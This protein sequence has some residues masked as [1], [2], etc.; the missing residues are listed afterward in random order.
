MTD[1]FDVPALVGKLVL[2]EPLDTGHIEGLARAAR[3]G[4]E[5]YNLSDVPNNEA[6]AR[7]YV[8]RAL[9][10]RANNSMVPFAVIDQR[11]HQVVGSTR[12]CYFQYWRWQEPHRR[13]SA[14]IPD[15]AEIGYTWL[16]K[17]A[18]G[19]GINRE[20]KLLMLEVAFEQWR[21]FRL[22][23][24]TDARNVR[25]RA[26]IEG[27]G[28]KFDGVLRAD[29]AAYDGAIRDSAVYSVLDSEWQYLKRHL[30]TTLSR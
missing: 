15:A 16:A 6:D 26:A 24:R 21:L 2:L 17:A 14:D 13:R 8:E 9:A 30:Q 12:F 7:R 25:S 10:G 28:A 20:A 5:R 27:L 1:F 4:R 22:R 11:T 23:L 29:G 19:T 3:D 18:Q